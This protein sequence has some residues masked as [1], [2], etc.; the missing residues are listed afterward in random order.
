[1]TFNLTYH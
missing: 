1:L